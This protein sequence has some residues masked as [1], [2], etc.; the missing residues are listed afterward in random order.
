[1]SS[2]KKLT[3]G[4]VSPSV[5]TKSL[6]QIENKSG[7]LYLSLNVI[8][9][10]ANQIAVELKEELHG[11]LEEFTTAS[12]N[13]EEVFENREQIEISRHYEKLPNPAIP[14][15]REFM[16]DRTHFHIPEGIELPQSSGQDFLLPE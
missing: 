3:S 10:R 4:H 14:A 9:K 11:K 15:T 16:E 7:N 13:L 5:E 6:R 12:D 2:I 8:A 1:M